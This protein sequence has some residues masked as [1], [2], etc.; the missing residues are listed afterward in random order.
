MIAFKCNVHAPEAREEHVPG[1][2]PSVEVHGFFEVR[3]GCRTQN[4]PREKDTSM[5]E[6]RLQ[7]EFFFYT[8]RAE[9]KFK[10]DMWTDG[11]T[12][13]LEYDTRE[14]WIFLRP[15]GFMD[16][17]A[18]RQVLTWGTGDLFFLNDLFPKDWQ[19]YFIGRDREYLKAPSDAVKISIFTE[20]VSIDVVYTPQLDP[21]RYI[22]GEFIS[23]WNAP[24]G[25]F[26]GRDAKGASHKPDRWLQ[27][28]EIGVRVYK[29]INNYELALYGYRGFWKSPGGHTPSGIAEFPALNV[30]G[31]SVRGR[32][33]PGIGNIEL[34]WYR[35]VDDKRGSNPL[36]NNSEMRYL[37]GYMQDL[38]K[39]FSAS[40]Q[41]YV[42]HMLKYR[43]YKKTLSCGPSRD[44]LRHV[45][46]VQLTK[47]LMNQN[48]E[49]HISSYYSPSDK[50]AY[51]RPNIRYKYTDK[52]TL[53]AGGNLFFGEKSH[54]FFGQFENNT[55]AYTSIRYSF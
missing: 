36:I 1:L 50:D 11:I 53:E 4:D 16:I 25:T 18:G 37:A 2:F 15:A 19:S 29:N 35:S 5:M 23:Y 8:D 6:A 54:T 40:F 42:E 3:A 33:G 22:T 52:I 24:L 48:L 7:A 20:L 41:Y 10:A 30:Y 32:V 44:R 45:I 26:A 47:L 43:E 31:A 39:D 38:G 49:L 13:R 34:A 12:E 9:F 46:T 27:D 55:N 21:D 17:K 14:A 51:L 28:D